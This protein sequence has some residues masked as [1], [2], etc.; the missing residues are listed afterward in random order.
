MTAWASVGFVQEHQPLSA[1][2]ALCVSAGQR[3]PP[4]HLPQLQMCFISSESSRL[5]LKKHLC[6]FLG[7]WLAERQFELRCKWER[8][9]HLELQEPGCLT[10]VLKRA[11]HHFTPLL[12]CGLLV[13]SMVTEQAEGFSVSL[14]VWWWLLEAMMEEFKDLERTCRLV[15]TE[16]G[17]HEI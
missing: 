3:F 13:V 11:S 7:L 15:Q 10:P 1:P 6:L 17:L 5:Y 12:V 14:L 16:E 8:L 4:S 2:A 9:L